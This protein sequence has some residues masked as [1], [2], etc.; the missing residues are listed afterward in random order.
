MGSW[1]FGLALP[2]TVGVFVMATI[3]TG[4]MLSLVDLEILDEL[5]VRR[6]VYNLVSNSM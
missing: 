5:G 2:L 6:S 3:S 1:L 4:G